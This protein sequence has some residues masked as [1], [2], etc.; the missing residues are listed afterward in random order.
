MS[1]NAGR[2]RARPARFAE[3]LEPR[4][5]LSGQLFPGEGPVVG[6]NPYSVI[7]G[8]FNGDGRADLATANSGSNTV[9]VALGNGDGTF[10]AAISVAVGKSP[11]SIFTG[12]FNGDGRADLATANSGSNTVSV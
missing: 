12:D 6:T 11:Q 2:R 3:R 10:A 1:E 7:S 9:S 5:L 4:R 8:D